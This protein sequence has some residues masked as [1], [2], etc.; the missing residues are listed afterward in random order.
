MVMVFGT[1]LVLCEQQLLELGPILRLGSA[2][3]CSVEVCSEQSVAGCR[4]ESRR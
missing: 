3:S 2:P 4:W 1:L